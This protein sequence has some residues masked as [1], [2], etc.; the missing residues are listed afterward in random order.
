MA[1]ILITGSN[2]F[3][4]KNLVRYWLANNED[5]DKLTTP[6][7]KDVNLVSYGSTY[8]YFRKL[9]K[10]DIVIHLAAL[11]GGIGI[12]QRRPGDFIYQNMMMGANVLE[13]AHQYDVRKVL[14][15][16]TV[17]Q[18][19]KFTPSP[20]KEDDIWNG[21]P[22]ETNAPYGIAKKAVMEM[23]AAYR[24][25]YG[26]NVVSLIP[27]NLIGEYDHFEDDRSH[28]V[29]ALIKKFGD[30]VRQQL[31]DVTV[32][33]DGTAS[34][35]FLDA[36]DCARAIYLAA[37]KYDGALPVNI[38]NGREVT[39]KELVN[40]ISKLMGYTGSI[41]WD[42]SKP[43]GQP[44]R[45]LDV[46]RAKELFGFEAQI[47]LKESLKNVIIYAWENALC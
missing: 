6:S 14:L 7:S 21:Y 39:I 15:L 4:G 24:R 31:S 40:E 11:C 42:A 32:W 17:C 46:S 23:G 34:R 16:G 19:P 41:T 37:K 3:L 47:P 1:H 25:Q 30:A 10:I 35:E 33:G 43:N 27:T 9:G 38:G 2:G 18:Y 44:R 26:M 13:A 45:C 22:E 5:I 29:P 8:Q 36:R 20:F 12:N 28:V